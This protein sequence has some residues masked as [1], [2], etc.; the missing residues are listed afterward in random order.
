[1]EAVIAAILIRTIDVIAY[2]LGCILLAVGV[3]AVAC[4][5]HYVL[6]WSGAFKKPPV[7]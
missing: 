6:R 3:F 2:L 1:M 7:P 5:V 4:C